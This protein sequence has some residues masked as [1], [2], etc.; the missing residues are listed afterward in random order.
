MKVVC[1]RRVNFDFLKD[2]PIRQLSVKDSLGCG[3]SANIAHADKKNSVFGVAHFFN[4]LK[5]FFKKYNRGCDYQCRLSAF[6][7]PP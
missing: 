7:V 2:F 1:T 6:H 5:S 4:W 3:T